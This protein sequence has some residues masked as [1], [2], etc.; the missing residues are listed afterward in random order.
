MIIT[1]EQLLGQIDAFLDKTG[2][3][4]T[5]FGLETLADGGLLKGLR[6]GRSLSLKNAQKVMLFMEHY[7]PATEVVED[8]GPPPFTKQAAA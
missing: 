2:M 4:P 6:E 7:A 1:D 5:R 3:A 8:T